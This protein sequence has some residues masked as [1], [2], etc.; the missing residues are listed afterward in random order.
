G[1]LGELVR[2][3]PVRFVFRAQGS[4]VGAKDINPGLG[5][6]YAFLGNGKT[7]VRA[8]IGRYPSPA[9]GLGFWGTSQNPVTRFAGSTDRA[10]TDFEG[11]FIPHCDLM[12]PAANGT[13]NTAGV[14]DCGACSNQSFGKVGP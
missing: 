2:L 12:N 14:F 5:F 8:S 13:Q 10:W 9:S 1:R 3:L 4:G 11:D 6:G 7:A